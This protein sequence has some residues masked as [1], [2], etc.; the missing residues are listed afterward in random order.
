M[1]MGLLRCCGDDL[2]FCVWNRKARCLMERSYEVCVKIAGDSFGG[3][4][5]T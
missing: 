5:K 1:V 2:G 3:G 4:R